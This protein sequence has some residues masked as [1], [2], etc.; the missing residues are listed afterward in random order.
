MSV[1]F[2]SGVLTVLSPCVF[3]FL[4]VIL[5]G[6]E[7]G[8]SIIKPL[9]IITSL[10]LSVFIFTLLLKASTF[11]IDI[12]V[13]V[14]EVVAGGILIVQGIIIVFPAFWGKVSHFL[15]IE[16]TSSVL[17]G[18]SEKKDTSVRDMF[19]G[20]ALGPIFTSCSPTYAYIVAVMLPVSFSIGIIYLT[21]YILGMSSLL[22]FISFFGNRLL[23]KFVNPNGVFKQVVG[24]VVL[25]MGIL[26]LFGI[27]KDVEATLLNFAPF[28]KLTVFDGNLLKGIR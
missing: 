5:K 3:T 10:S 22:L 26:I 11:L 24:W 18:I 2:T 21:I 27:Y 19:L 14:W 7:G 6:V 16:N 13:M 4:P 23:R 8:V 20:F 12:P 25:I 15:G 9:R 17:A 28:L 1:A